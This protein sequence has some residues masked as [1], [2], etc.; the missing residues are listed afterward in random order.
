MVFGFFWTILYI[1]EQPS[2][3]IGTGQMYAVLKT[4]NVKAVVSILMK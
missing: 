4:V 3:F 2:V 1:T